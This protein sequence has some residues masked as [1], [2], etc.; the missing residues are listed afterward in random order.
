MNRLEPGLAAEFRKALGVG[1]ETRVLLYQT[2][3]LHAGL[4]L[5]ISDL[6]EMSRVMGAYGIGEVFPPG[7]AVALAASLD[8]MLPSPQALAG[9]RRGSERAF[10]ELNWD[11]KK[12]TLAAV[13]R[14]FLAANK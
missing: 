8:R 7:D 12:R 9:Y 6:P 14:H 13:Y 1:P 11:H 2:G 5:A 4:P 10:T 3:V